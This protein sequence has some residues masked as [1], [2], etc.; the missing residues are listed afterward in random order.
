MAYQRNPNDSVVLRERFY[1]ARDRYV[2]E[3]EKGHLPKP[4]GD[5]RLALAYLREAIALQSEILKRE[6]NAAIIAG[7]TGEMHANLA[8]L[9]AELGQRQDACAPFVIADRY[10]R[11]RKLPLRAS[12]IEAFKEMDEKLPECKVK[13]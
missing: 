6:P 11:E 5:L 3:W 10:R 13:Q 1:L 8:T 12:E 9:L 7:D 4:T 2:N